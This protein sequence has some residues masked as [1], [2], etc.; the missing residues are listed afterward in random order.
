MKNSCYDN[1]GLVS[2]ALLYAYKKFFKNFYDLFD[3]LMASGYLEILSH[4]DSINSCVSEKD[5]FFK[6]FQWA[7]YGFQ[8]LLNNEIKNSHN[9]Y[10]LS[11]MSEDFDDD[12][13]KTYFVDFC[14]FEY[15]NM[16][17]LLDKLNCLFSTYS[18]K[19]MSVLK[20]YFFGG[21]TVVELSKFFK[22]SKNEIPLLI[23]DFRNRFFNSLIACGYFS[24]K[25]KSLLNYNE[26]AK[27]EKLPAVKIC[28]LLKEANIDIEDIAKI[29]CLDVCRVKDILEHKRNNCKF[30]LWQ[31][32]KLR[33]AY[34]LNYSL[35]E[36]AT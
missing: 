35:E 15:G 8:K 6:C 3:D 13:F 1:L 19:E 30:F 29:T 5:K 24:E 36:L 4:K 28:T 20:L 23:L 17:F 26:F 32:Q 25:D 14:S 9:S 22:M 27:K 31:I 12:L 18:K 7:C 11:S 2:R 33:K 21:Y 16:A 34:F 10:S